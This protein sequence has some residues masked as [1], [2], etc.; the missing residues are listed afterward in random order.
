ML[1]HVEGEVVK[2]AETPDA[3]PEE[4][5]D[6]ERGFFQEQQNRRKHR[7]QQE[8][9]RLG[10]NPDRTGEF[11]HVRPSRQP[12]RLFAKLWISEKPLGLFAPGLARVVGEPDFAGRSGDLAA[13]NIRKFDRGYVCRE[14][15]TI[16]GGLD[17]LPVAA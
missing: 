6:P 4:K 11:A 9:K 2:T 14:R 8:K 13:A 10:S 12:F 7:Q 5:S 16:G 15:G 1:D 17:L 3:K